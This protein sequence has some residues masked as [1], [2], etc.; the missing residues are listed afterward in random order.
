MFISLAD[1]RGKNGENT[2][3]EMI[4]NEL[5]TTQVN[6]QKPQSGTIKLQTVLSEE[7]VFRVSITELCVSSQLYLV[8]TQ[9]LQGD[10][11]PHFLIKNKMLQHETELRDIRSLSVKTGNKLRKKVE[12]EL[13]VNDQS[14]SALTV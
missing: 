2:S 14:V 6:L 12:F 4:V 1:K 3:D 5:F 8:K 9:R 7:Q 10:G 11:T 13:P